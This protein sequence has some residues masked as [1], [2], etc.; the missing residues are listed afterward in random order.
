[1]APLPAPQ[2]S[3]TLRGLRAQVLDAVV[4]MKA[5]RPGPV[6]AL[7]HMLGAVRQEKAGKRAMGNLLILIEGLEQQA[8]PQRHKIMILTYCSIVH[9]GI[10][11]MPLPHW[12]E[13]F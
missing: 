8:I 12:S 10:E 2:V 4:L 11:L 13:A 3:G 6:A 7:D 5:G 9:S 1:M